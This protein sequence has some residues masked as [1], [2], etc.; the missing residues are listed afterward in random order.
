MKAQRIA[1]FLALAICISPLI[2]AEQPGQPTIDVTGS[3]TLEIP[4]TFAKITVSVTTLDKDAAKAQ[5]LNDQKVRR[6][7]DA[8]EKFGVEGKDVSTDDISL[9]EKEA[10]VEGKAP[11]SLGYE[12]SNRLT[13]TLRNMK[14]YD[15]L[16]TALL[17]AGI[18]GIRGVEFG[19]DEEIAKR[20]EARIT[21]IKAAKEKADYLAAALGQKVCAPIKIAE[22][23]RNSYGYGNNFNAE[24]VLMAPMVSRASLAPKNITINASVDVTFLLCQ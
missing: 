13:I 19:S 21:A 22:S 3:A 23:A 4:P 17:V 7:L 20:K 6:A 15:N 14:E 16:I 10:E 1:L 5:S 18:N 12:A 11:L 24:I 2:M 8:V 9:E